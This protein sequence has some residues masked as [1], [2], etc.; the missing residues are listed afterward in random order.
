[1]Q[2]LWKGKSVFFVCSFYRLLTISDLGCK[3]LAA[4]LRNKFLPRRTAYVGDLVAWL[5]VAQTLLPTLPRA[6]WQLFPPEAALDPTC[7]LILQLRWPPSS[8]SSLCTDRSDEVSAKP[9][10]S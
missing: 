9:W 3:D 4:H 8:A 2:A 10:P 6:H 7:P 5:S 1:M